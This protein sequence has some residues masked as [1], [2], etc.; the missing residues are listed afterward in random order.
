MI[1][2]I[3]L[4]SYL[5]HINVESIKKMIR[6]DVADAAVVESVPETPGLY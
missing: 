4:S 5:S 6:N 3:D 2:Y 1:K